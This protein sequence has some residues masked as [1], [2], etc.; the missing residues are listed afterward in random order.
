[1]EIVLVKAIAPG[2]HDRTYVSR[3]G[4]SERVPEHPVHDLPHLVVESLFHIDGLWAE[5]AQGGHSDVRAAVTARDPKRQKFG[6][7]VSGAANGGRTETWLSDGHRL[8]KIATNSVVNRWGDGPNT[9][10][11][12]RRRL[13]GAQGEAGAILLERL[14]D[15]TIA[16]AIRAVRELKRRW[17][18]TPP[19]GTL[20]LEWPLPRSFFDPDPP[21]L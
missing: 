20:R 13:S 19:G 17:A 21:P 18:A 10:A 4:K 15:E 14:D 11:G 1:V 7:I 3:G 8:A 5:L 12:V 6:R 2:D 9:P 16:L